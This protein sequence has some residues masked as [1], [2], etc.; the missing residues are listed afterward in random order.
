[1][2]ERIEPSG[3]TKVSALGIAEQRVNAI[4]TLKDPPP[5]DLGH[6]FRVLANWSP[7]RHRQHFRCR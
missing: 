3:F 7:G 1:V 4:L 5:A 2:V 6:G